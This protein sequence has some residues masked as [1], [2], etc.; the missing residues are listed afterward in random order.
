MRETL[1]VMLKDRLL[2]RFL[3]GSL[4]A[5]AFVWMAIRYFRVEPEVV[6]VLLVFSVGLVLLLLIAGLL[7]A[8]V[9]RRFKRRPPTFLSLTKAKPPAD[10]APNQESP[11]SSGRINRPDRGR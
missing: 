9:L 3:L 1:L 10:E 4:F 2:R 11:H 5:G 6:W 8:P 7:V